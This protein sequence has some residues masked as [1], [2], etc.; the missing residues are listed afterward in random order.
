MRLTPMALGVLKCGIHLLGV[1][2]LGWLILAV[3]QDYFGADAAKELIKYCGRTA[4]EFLFLTLL[5]SP[6]ALWTRTPALIRVR[7]LVGLWCFFWACLHLLAFAALELGWELKLLLVEVVKRP[8]LLL[9]SVSW[10]LLLALAVTSNRAPDQLYLNGINRQLFV[11]FIEQIEARCEVVSL[12]G[13][14]DWRLHRLTGGKVWFSPVDDAARQGFEDL[15]SDLRGG[16]PEEPA[17]LTVLGRDVVVER[18]AGSMARATF[19]ELCRRPLGPQDY[20]AIA[21]RFHTLFLEDVPLLSPANQQEA[22]R[23]VTLIDAL[24]EAHA[25]LIVLAEAEPTAL[26]PEGDGAFEF[27]RTASRL[28]E[29]QAADWMTRERSV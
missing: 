6:L 24:Y 27:E 3:Q 5:I 28:N 14:R 25:R 20:L 23:L 2:L 10:S 17:H 16:E 7:R 29:M 13:E 15:W 1:A 11:P 18:T 9:G 8:Y 4:L 19:A 12:T 22:R 26:Y 21:E